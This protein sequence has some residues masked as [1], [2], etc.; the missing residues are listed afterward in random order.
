MD[1]I[2]TDKSLIAADT[3]RLRLASDNGNVLPEFQPGAH[4]EL[5]FAEL[6]RRY[7]LT[8]SPHDLSSYEIC[9]LHTN[10]SRGGSAYLHEELRVGARLQ[11]AGPFNAFPLHR[12]A[13]HTVFIAGGIGITPFLSMM[14]VLDRASRSFEL[15]YV[16]R[17]PDRFLPVSENSGRIHRYTKSGNSPKLDIEAI[18]N[19]LAIDTEL[20]VCGPRRLIEAVR[21]E[22]AA[23]GW[24]D[25]QI[26]FESFGVGLDPDDAPVKVHLAL[27]GMTIDVE[28]GT[29]ILDA[30]LA[31]GVWAPYECKRGECGSCYTEL[32]SGEPEHR[33]LCLTEG[34]RRGGICTCVSWGKTPEIVLNL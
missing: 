22:A 7:S 29:S 14:E 17:S 16:A 1:L 6:T 13:R 8:S 20:Y 25:N 4:I 32:V 5:S 15:H 28:P 31:N 23:L 24:P 34:Q 33:D 18:L 9:V 27:S 26:H 12:T 30:L 3:L 10:P 19:S 21:V 2:I 11:G